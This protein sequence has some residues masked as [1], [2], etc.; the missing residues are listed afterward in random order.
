MG[1]TKDFLDGL[2]LT[3]EELN[4]EL[5]SRGDE[6]YQYQKWI[7]SP[8]FVE[9][10]NGEIDSTRPRY[11]EHDIMSATRYASQQI[12]I[13]PSE[14]GKEVYDMLFSEKIEEYLTCKTF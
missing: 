4:E 7:D 13:E 11:S 12:T 2:N 1:R 3:E 5:Y 10:V 14:V 8:E 6:G 9:Y